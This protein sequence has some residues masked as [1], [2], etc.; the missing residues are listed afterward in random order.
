MDLDLC[1]EKDSLP[2]TQQK[3]KGLQRLVSTRLKNLDGL[4]CPRL[5]ACTYKLEVSVFPK[6]LVPLKSS[7]T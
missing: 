6:A 7:G 4:I 1:F 3:A 2:K 5:D